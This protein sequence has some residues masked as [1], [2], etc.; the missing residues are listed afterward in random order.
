MGRHDKHLP[1][2]LTNST[3]KMK[4]DGMT[5]KEKKDIADGEGLTTKIVAAHVKASDKDGK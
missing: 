2:S 1:K 3:K 4:I 5:A